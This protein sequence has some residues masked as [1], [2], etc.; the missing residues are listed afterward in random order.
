MIQEKLRFFAHQE[1][2]HEPYTRRDHIISHMSRGID[3]FNRGGVKFEAS[4]LNY[5]SAFRILQT[6]GS[7]Y[8][9][10]LPQVT[11][12]GLMQMPTTE[13]YLV[14]SADYIVGEEAQH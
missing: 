9:M 4:G 3:L 14:N 5:T 7:K 8:R 6:Q 12:Q 11:T 13:D 2:N 10:F 1:Y